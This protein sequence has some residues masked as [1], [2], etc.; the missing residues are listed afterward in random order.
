MTPLAQNI[1]GARSSSIA[2]APV[3]A[4][5]RERAVGNIRRKELTFVLRNLA[6]L[7]DNGIPLAK[8]LAT[9]CQERSLRKHALLLD[10]IRRDLEA[11]ATFSAAL[12]RFPNSFAPVVVNQVRVA[13]KSGTLAATLDRVAI[14]LENADRTRATVIKKLAYPMILIVAGACSMSFML[15]FVVPVFQKTYSD[16]GVP[17]PTIT[18]LLIGVADFAKAFGVYI[19][20]SIVAAVYMLCEM[21]RRPAAG[22]AIDGALFRLPIFGPWMRNLSVLQFM[23]VLGNLLEAGFNVVEALQVAATTVNNRVIR[24]SVE[25]MQTAVL[26]GERFSREV[27]K[28]GDLFPPVVVQLIV[29]GERTGNLPKI[30]VRIREHL[31]QEIERQTTLMVG[32]IEPVLTIGLAIMIGIVILAIYLPMFDMINALNPGA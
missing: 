22:M 16:A 8:A 4:R 7:V 27:D 30:T 20:L 14:Q 11:G 10:S 32:A 29:V 9:L 17:L 5:R 21:R 15:L 6:T 25:H 31:R 1:A 13:E 24:A 18:R 23:E 12:G 19:V 28:L 26:Q 3:A 2:T